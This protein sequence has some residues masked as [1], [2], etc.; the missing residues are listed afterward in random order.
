MT[1]EHTI[2]A[3]STNRALRGAI[4]RRPVLFYFAIAFGMVWLLLL[5]FVLG[6]GGLG[7]LPFTMPD[8][9]FIVA[10]IGG[11][12]L[13]PTGGA[14]IVTAATEGGAG[15]RRLLR[16]YVQWRVGI[17]WY[18]LTLLGYFALYLAAAVLAGGVAPV[19]AFFSSRTLLLT[20][21]PLVLLSMILFP[22]LFEEPGWRGFALPR[23][24]MAYGPLVGTLLLGLLHSLWHLPVYI[25]V[26]GPAAMDPF[27]LAHLVTNTFGIVA[28]TIIWT[29]VI[30]HAKGS[31]L[32]AILLHAASN[33]SDKMF[34]QLVPVLPPQIGTTA[35][36]L[37][38]VGATLLVV[39][40]RGRLGY[41]PEA[42]HGKVERDTKNSIG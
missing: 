5:P 31:I 11:T 36:E 38:L 21:Y 22:A 3:L 9:A 34:G 7:L 25:L 10:F 29:W 24:Q 19:V 39:L 33:A 16:R 6:Q 30:N 17:H 8:V 23:L 27:N 42:T 18:A 13:G 20:A 4:A 41:V 14:F 28:L 26:D 40:T 2:S 32:V 37:M 15:I 12:L 1:A 35:L